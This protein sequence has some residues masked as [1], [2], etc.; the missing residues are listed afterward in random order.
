M[1][2]V[3]HRQAQVE[4]GSEGL[5]V[6]VEYHSLEQMLESVTAIAHGVGLDG[7]VDH[8]HQNNTVIRHAL[9]HFAKSK[10]RQL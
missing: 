6:E 5:D 3:L 4:A 7:D 8:V 1:P 9:I 2:V 10:G